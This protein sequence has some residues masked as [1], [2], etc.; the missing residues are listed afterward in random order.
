MARVAT[1]LVMEGVEIVNLTSPGWI[2]NKENLD[3]ATSLCAELQLKKGD[4]VFLDLW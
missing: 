2:P 4:C 1:A 3:A